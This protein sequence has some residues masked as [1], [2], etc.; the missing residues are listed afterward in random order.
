MAGLAVDGVVPLTALTFRDADKAKAWSKRL[1]AEVIADARARGLSRRRVGAPLVT[2]LTALAAVAASA[3]AT[4]PTSTSC[5]P[6]T[7]T[8][9]A[10]R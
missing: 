10:A 6:A 3:P 2:A 1:R 9:P 4:W 8:R 5:A 7:T